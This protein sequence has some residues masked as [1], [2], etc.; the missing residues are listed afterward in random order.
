MARGVAINIL[1]VNVGPKLNKRLN[2][3][4]NA[5]DTRD[6]QRR[7]EVICPRIDLSA[8]LNEYFYHWG[9]TLTRSKMKRCETIRVC[10]VNNFIKF[11]V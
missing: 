9:V 3:T 4:K 5:S 1:C 11:V 6:M 7:S 8:K 2:Y 10:A